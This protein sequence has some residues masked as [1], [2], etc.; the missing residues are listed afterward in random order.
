MKELIETGDEEVMMSLISLSPNMVYENPDGHL[1]NYYLR[2]LSL[3][4]CMLKKTTPL[5]YTAKFKMP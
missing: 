2:A 5:L 4:I 3:D 1:L